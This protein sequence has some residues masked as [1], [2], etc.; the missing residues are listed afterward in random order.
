MNTVVCMFCLPDIL[1][2]LSMS[3]LFIL[4]ITLRH[5]YLLFFVFVLLLRCKLLHHLLLLFS[6]AASSPSSAAAAVVVSYSRN[7][8]DELDAEM[9]ARQKRRKKDFH[10][11]ISLFRRYNSENEKAKIFMRSVWIPFSCN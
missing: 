3:S 8:K 4:V 7:R 2:F 1:F 5:F 11:P 10:L 9:H 6:F